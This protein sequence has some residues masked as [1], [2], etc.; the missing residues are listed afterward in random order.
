MEN[1]KKQRRSYIK[2]ATSDTTQVIE[3][4][5]AREKEREWEREGEK[6]T[7]MDSEIE[8]KMGKRRN[9]LSKC[10]TFHLQQFDSVAEHLH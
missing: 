4:R 6:G 1:E 9:C 2:M 7:A 5:Q 10:S 3:S 8:K